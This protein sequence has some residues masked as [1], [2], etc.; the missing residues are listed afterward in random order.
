MIQVNFLEHERDEKEGKI[1]SV[2]SYSVFIKKVFSVVV[3]FKN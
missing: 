3:S 1:T 2:S